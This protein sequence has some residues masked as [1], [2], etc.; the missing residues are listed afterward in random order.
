M[1][2]RFFWNKRT[3][4]GLKKGIEFFRQAIEIDPTYA[5]AY[6]GIADCYAVL[7]FFGDLP[8]K[9][10]A[11]K[12]T[13]AAKKALA[14][15]DSL[16]EVHS[17]LGLVNLIYDWDWQSAEREFKRAI[18][19]SP[20]YAT[21]RDWYSSYLMAIGKVDDALE[22]MKHARE[23]DPLSPIISTG[24]ARQF[25]YARQSER[26]VQECLKILDME[27][28]FAPAHWFLGQ[29]YEQLGRYDEAISQLQQAVN[30]SQGR[31]LMLGSLGYT[32]GVSGRS[33]EAQGVLTRL[34]DHSPENIP[35]LAIAFVHAGLG[36]Y[37]AAFEWLDKAYEE[38][39]GWLIFLNV[40]PKLDGLRSDPRFTKLLQRLKLA[41]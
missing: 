32:Y 39:F 3:E 26:A 22:E 7:C 31:A 1:K 4:D 18:K 13:A 17:S 25:Y 34:Q 41:T 5:L 23:L 33:A 10:S 36:Q 29:A 15:D 19:L 27:S 21:A 12:A 16:A 2:G 38:R 30:H 35:A 28:N 20:N 24:L 40:D 11:T 8:P 6:A 9:E 37:D 14:I